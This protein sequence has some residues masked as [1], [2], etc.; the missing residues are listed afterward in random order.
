MAL[1]LS[2]N[3]WPSFISF[4]SHVFDFGPGRD[5]KAFSIYTKLKLFWK[6]KVFKENFN[7]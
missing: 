4:T 1:R 7:I 2:L 3:L 6:P 5:C